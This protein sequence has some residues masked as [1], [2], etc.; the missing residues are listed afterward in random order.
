MISSFYLFPSAFQSLA[1]APQAH[2]SFILLTF[3]MAAANLK[4]QENDQK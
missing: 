4:S 3:Y 2:S 1:T